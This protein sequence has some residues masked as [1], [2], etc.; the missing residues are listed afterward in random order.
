MSGINRARWL[1]L[2]FSDPSMRSNITR[3]W[4]GEA[5]GG[6]GFNMPEQGVMRRLQVYGTC[7]AHVVNGTWT[8]TLYKDGV[9]AGN[10]CFQVSVA[11][12]AV[13]QQIALLDTSVGAGGADF[14]TGTDWFLKYDY[15]ST[16]STLELTAQVTAELLG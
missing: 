5:S 4:L 14:G 15:T 6:A 12:T 3:W 7:I 10:I 8:C 13:N 16:N 2:P 9:A 1:V 11:I